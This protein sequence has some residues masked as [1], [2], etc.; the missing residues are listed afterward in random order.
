MI[1]RAIAAGVPFAGAA[2]D[3]AY[4]DYA[5]LPVMPAGA[6]EPVLCS[7]FRARVSA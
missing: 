1:E 2:A 6:A 7:G 3:E 5:D 4:G